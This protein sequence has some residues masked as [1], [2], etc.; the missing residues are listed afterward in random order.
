MTAAMMLPTTLP[1]VR[2]FD[3]MIAARGDSA[4]LHASL[5]TGYLGA[6][7]TFGMMM[8]WIDWL[9]HVG[10]GGWPWLARRPWFPS[11]VILA[12]AGAF[13][14]SELKY[15][16]LE[17]CRTPLGFILGYWHGGRPKREAFNVGWAHGIYCIGCCWALMLLM[18]AI[19]M[20][21]LGWMLLLGSLMALEKNVSWGRHLSVPI[22][23]ALLI[24]SGLIGVFELL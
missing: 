21:N 20:G 10:L 11:L 7:S 3:R 18:F 9:L 12:I 5:I 24:S 23:G 17:K 8:Y 16:C 4:A 15:H 22:G 19:G 13:Q 1:L 14:F 6:W 2:L